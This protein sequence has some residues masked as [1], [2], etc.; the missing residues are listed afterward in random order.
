MKTNTLS[1]LTILRAKER[2]FADHGWLKAT[3]TFSFADY[4]DP[5]HMNY[6]TLRVMNEDRVAPGMGFGTHPHRDM[7]IVTYVI[8]GQLEHKDS[9]G[10]GRVI[11]PGDLQYMSAGTGVY[12]S[13]FNPSSHDPVHL[14][15]IWILP[16]ERNAKPRYEEKALANAEP[17]KWHLAASKT[18][19]DGSMAIRQDADILLGKLA[20]GDSL[21]H[22]V[23][24]GRGA[25]LQVVEGSVTLN[26]ETL[27]PG[28]GASLDADADTSLEVTAS[29]DS[30]VLLFDLK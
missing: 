28:D 8:S 7:E 15:Q 4:Y 23:R 2:G 1:G 17:G 12:H 5:A 3:H 16:D 6:R 20:S 29:K 26:G 18:G 10:N 25:W 22:T 30:T 9:M 13:E 11:R 24:K 21:S 27:Q 14:Y 19:R